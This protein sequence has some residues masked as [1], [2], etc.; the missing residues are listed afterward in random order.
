VSH[1][2]DGQDRL[3]GA[4]LRQ[5]PARTREIERRAAAARPDRDALREVLRDAGTPEA[6]AA[7]LRLARLLRRRW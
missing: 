4:L 2:G 7:L 6:Q 1:D 3:I 5:Q